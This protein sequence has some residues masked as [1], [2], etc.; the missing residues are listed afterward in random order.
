MFQLNE[1]EWQDLKSQNATSSLW[2]GRRK[3]PYAFSEHGVLMLSSVLSSQRAIAVNIRIMRVYV[4]IRE[5]MYTNTD[6]LARLNE[7]DGKLAVQDEKIIRLFSLMQ[8]QSEKETPLRKK[9]GYK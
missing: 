3:L 5:L 7:V 2:G 6:L 8:R 4:K 1:N 9:V